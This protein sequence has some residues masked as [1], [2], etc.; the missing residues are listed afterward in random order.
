MTSP[1]TIAV[2]RLFANR[3]DES[4][5][6]YDI[7]KVL[8][9]AKGPVYRTLNKLEAAEFVYSEWDTQWNKKGARRKLYTASVAGIRFYEAKMASSGFIIK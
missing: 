3:A 2:L 9:R 6:G 7:A 8:G 5:C 1:E 4:L